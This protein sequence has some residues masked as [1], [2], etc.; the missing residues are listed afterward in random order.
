M[1][2]LPLDPEPTT[3]NER[4]PFAVTGAKRL[5]NAS[6]ALVGQVRD[7]IIGCSIG[8]FGATFVSMHWRD[9]SRRFG[10]VSLAVVKF[11]AA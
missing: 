3:T 8:K 6:Q 4:A 10:L 7:V 11:S 2:A 5:E 1:T 9:H